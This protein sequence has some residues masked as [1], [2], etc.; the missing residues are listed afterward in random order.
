MNRFY[1]DVSTGPAIEGGYVVLLDGR[2][3]R[4]PQKALMAAPTESLIKRIADEWTSQG[5]TIQ[6]QTMPLTQLLTTAIDRIH[7]RAEITQEVLKY[8]NGDLLCYR[9]GDPEA[10]AAEQDRLWNPPLRWFEET[11]GV[12]LETTFALSRLDQPDAAHV[13]TARAI[14]GMDAHEFTVFQ[15]VVSLTGSIV[16]ALALTQGA[17]SPE[18]ALNATLCEEL[19][20]ERTLDLTRHGLDPIEEKRRASL[21]RDLEAAQ[22]Y[23]KSTRTSH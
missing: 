17:I 19:F 15:M 16:L 22:A 7:M 12:S 10:L 3:V 5:E 18:D 2:P 4:T 8:L 1:K 23:L 6:A 13:A 20:Y 21:S 14:A 9:A 11:Y